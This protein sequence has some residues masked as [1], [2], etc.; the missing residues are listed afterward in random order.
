[1]PELTIEQYSEKAI[2]VRGNTQQYK[3]NLKELGGKWNSRLIGGG[4][5]I[6]PNAK[7]SKIEELNTQIDA[8]SIKA[9]LVEQKQY[10]SQAH[11][12]SSYQKPIDNRAFVPMKDYLDL[13]S[14]VERLESVISQLDF[15]K[16]TVPKKITGNVKIEMSGSEDEEP[17]KVERMLKRKPIKK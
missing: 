3:E 11:Q 1:M 16:G 9:I 6:F 15:V 7:K 17:E 12:P 8:G 4:G 10:E 2:A 14:R 13:M 5:W